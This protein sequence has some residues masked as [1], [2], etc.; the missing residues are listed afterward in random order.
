MTSKQD[1][2]GI[3]ACSEGGLTHKALK[4][5]KAAGGVDSR[6]NYPYQDE[7]LQVYQ[8]KCD[9]KR[10]HVVYLQDT[11]QRKERLQMF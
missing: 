9:C 4:Y 3:D 7:H 10:H 5:M 1:K 8:R 11:V 6:E 2:L